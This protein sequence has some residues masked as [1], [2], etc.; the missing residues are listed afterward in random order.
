MARLTPEQLALFSKMMK[1]KGIETPDIHTIAPR[2][3]GAEAPLSFDQHR[4]WFMDHLEPGTSLYNDCVAVRLRGAEIDTDVFERALR[5]VVA[6]HEIMRTAFVAEDGNPVQRIQDTCEFALEVHDL[7]ELEAGARLARCRKIETEQVRGAFDL[8]ELPLFRCDLIRLADDEYVFA[9]TMHHIISDGVS[10]GIIYQ[11]LSALYP[12]LQRGEPSPLPP[13]RVQFG[14][15]AAWER[16]AF[17]GDEMDDLVDHWK[18][19]LS[20]DLPTLRLPVDNPRTED[21][22]NNGALHRFRLSDGL[23]RDIGEYCKREGLTPYNVLLAGYFAL[24]HRHSGQEDILLG[25]PSSNRTNV[26][27]EKMIGFFIHTIVIRLGL[28]GNPTFRELVQRTRTASSDAFEHQDIPFERLVAAVVPDRKG[29]R[30]PLIQAWFCHMNSIIPPLELPGSTCEYE[31]ADTRNARFDL[32]MILD[33][34]GGGI[35]GWLEYDTDLFLPATIEALAAEYE[36]LLRHAL[37]H[38][39]TTLSLLRDTLAS[40][41]RQRRESE[42]ATRR[43]GR[44]PVRLGKLKRKRS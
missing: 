39:D 17:S 42:R 26:D 4:M 9:M 29:A 3:T 14:D 25:T 35:E 8:H 2:T 5:E 38:P 28:A 32:A 13:L 15:Y 43:G 33:E 23:Y 24:L 12:A 27:T 44:R 41:S 11:E 22:K 34:S 7:R 21:A 16:A 37:D 10:Y 31:V 30:M 40:A 6:R 19:V 20:G 36:A 18:E 1:E